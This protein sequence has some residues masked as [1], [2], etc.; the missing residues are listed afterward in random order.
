MFSLATTYCLS[1]QNLLHLIEALLQHTDMCALIGV[2]T[3]KS[4]KTISFS[5]HSQ[6]SMFSVMC[7]HYPRL[8]SGIAIFES[9][10]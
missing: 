8:Y 1:Q 5:G 3:A 7:A 2:V 10:A 9:S 6:G 4:P